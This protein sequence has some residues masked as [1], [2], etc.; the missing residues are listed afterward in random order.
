MEKGQGDVIFAT[1]TGTAPTLLGSAVSLCLHLG[2]LT[3]DSGVPEV[4]HSLISQGVESPEGFAQ[5]RREQ[6]GP[7]SPLLLCAPHTVT[8][9]FPTSI[10]HK[11]RLDKVKEKGPL[12]FKGFCT[13]AEELSI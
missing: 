8:T 2:M 1:Q 4:T 6:H 10:W 13:G 9:D 12:V 11:H 3:R 7:L 5:G